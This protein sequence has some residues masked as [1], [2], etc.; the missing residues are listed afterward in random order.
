V[1]G[2]DDLI[3]CSL[4]GGK[5]ASNA[6]E[7]R[8]MPRYSS[9][10]VGPSFLSYAKGMLKV[11][12]KLLISIHQSYAIKSYKWAND[13]GGKGGDE[14][15]PAVKHLTHSAKVLITFFLGFL[16]RDRCWPPASVQASVEVHCQRCVRSVWLCKHQLFPSLH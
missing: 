5:G 7:S 9:S 14:N 11:V 16:G 4:S 15:G 8:R 13:K 3:S 12:L 1:V 2:R 6:A 10:V